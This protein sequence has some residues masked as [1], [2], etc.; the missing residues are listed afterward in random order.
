MMLL[1]LN[2]QKLPRF[3]KQYLVWLEAHQRLMAAILIVTLWRLCLEIVNQFLERLIKFSGGSV[4]CSGWISSSLSRWMQWDGGWY[5]SII[6]NGYHYLASAPLS[7]QTVAFF[8]VFPGLVY[9]LHYITRFPVV[10]VG[11]GA[12]LCLAIGIAYV[13]Y[14]L[15]LLLRDK[16]NSSPRLPM[17]KN[18]GGLLTVALIFA[19]PTAFFMAAFYAEALLVFCLL[20]AIYLSFKKNYVVAA[21]FAGLASATNITGIVAMPTVILIFID[22]E[23]VIG[24]GLRKSISKYW[25]KILLLGLAGI[26]GLLSYMGYLW[27][28]FKDPL[29]FYKSEQAWGRRLGDPLI[30]IWNIYYRHFFDVS[31]FGGHLNYLVALTDMLVPILAIV[32]IAY[33]IYKRVWWIAAYAFILLVLPL[34]SGRLSSINRYA[35]ALSP[36][37]IYLCAVSPGKLQKYLW[38]IIPLLA[39]IQ[40]ILVAVFLQGKFFVG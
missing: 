6:N 1:M 18:D 8:P 30:N 35:L 5:S 20:L 16:Y 24:Y 36:C 29:V 32:F 7:Y 12:N 17:A 33:V 13:A 25:Y 14:K 4:S 28:K 11:E 39:F 15:W 37:I 34:S 19:L 26:W 9:I 21:F 2:K 23:S 31:F 27:V 38:M 40:I 10:I 22:Q 3:F